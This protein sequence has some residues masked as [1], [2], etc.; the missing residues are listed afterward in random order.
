MYQD[1]L[2]DYFTKIMVSRDM[3]S[4]K[5]VQCQQ[6]LWWSIF[7]SSLP[8]GSTFWRP[9]PS[10]ASILLDASIFSACTCGPWL[11]S[12]EA[13]LSQFSGNSFS[14]R[15]LASFLPFV[16]IWNFTVLGP[17][18][19]NILLARSSQPPSLFFLCIWP[20]SG[21]TLSPSLAR[22]DWLCCWYRRA[23]WRGP[24]FLASRRAVTALELS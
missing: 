1:L 3:H 23:G 19:Q 16:G 11:L 4:T 13:I 22:L 20:Y 6:I 10:A 21:S 2:I 15:L 18:S 12:F 7:F 8:R 5:A 17:F 24:R 14:L 9:Y